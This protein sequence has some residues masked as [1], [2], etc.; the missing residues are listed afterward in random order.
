MIGILVELLVS[1]LLLWLCHRKNLSVL[2]L[3]PSKK[4]L[5]DFLVGCLISALLCAIYFFSIVRI[6]GTQ[7]QVNQ[8]FSFMDFLSGFW[9]TLKSVL[10]EEF[11]FRGA[12]L[13]IAIQ[14]FGTKL[15][16]ILSAVAFGIYHWFS[17][18]VFGDPMQMT[19]IFIVTGI[20]GL[21]F[22]YAFA[23][24]KSL[25][26]PIGLHLGWNVVTIVVFSQGPLGH[27][28][29]ITTSEQKL[30][31]ILSL[32]LF[33]FQLLALPIFTYL[34]LRRRRKEISLA[35]LH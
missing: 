21:M 25:Y 33:L 23:V 9:W 13:Y 26:L 3:L 7:L 6:S 34:Y 32:L 22:A 5:A 1:W 35:I 11:L 31:G 30:T 27:Q 17:Y 10:F 2:G 24:T 19:L 20:G 14:R 29:L 4:L 8:G 28:L 12:L 16:C 15:G 18:G